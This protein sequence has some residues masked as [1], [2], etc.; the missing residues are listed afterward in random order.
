MGELENPLPEVDQEEHPLRVLSQEN[1]TVVSTFTGTCASRVFPACLFFLSFVQYGIYYKFNCF[2]VPPPTSP[3]RRFAVRRQRHRASVFPTR[4]RQFV[5][6]QEAVRPP[7][8]A[9]GDATRTEIVQRY[10]RAA[11]QRFAWKTRKS[12][13]VFFYD[14][15]LARPHVRSSTYAM[16]D[17]V[18]FG[19]SGAIYTFLFIYLH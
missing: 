1:M 14:F 3:R 13:L 5:V 4:R 6:V 19:Y 10:A 16:Y 15:H 2:F 17:T 8:T 11:I 18:C 9:V 12:I 7:Q